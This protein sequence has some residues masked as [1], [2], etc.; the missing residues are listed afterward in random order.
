LI[1]EVYDA[2]AEAEAT[3]VSYSSPFETVGKK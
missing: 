2:M 1:L 3:G